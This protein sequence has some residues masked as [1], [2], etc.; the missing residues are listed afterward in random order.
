MRELQVVNAAELA[1]AYAAAEYA[2]LL[3]G[4]PLPL[5]VGQP[6]ADLEAYWPATRY[7]FITAWN[8][9][10]EPRSESAN[11]AADRLL[12][13]QLDEARFAR[14]PA[15][16]EDPAGDWREHGWLLADIEDTAAERL[17]REFGQAAVLA[18]QRGEP[19]RLRM[20]MPRPPATDAA[21]A[22]TDWSSG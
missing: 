1:I 11:Q 3:D 15:W 14:H 22:Y 16:A 17:A 19:V 13:T 9:A 10:S 8:P 6:A 4:E 2:V 20:L 18:W 21:G 12:V 5:R 7:L